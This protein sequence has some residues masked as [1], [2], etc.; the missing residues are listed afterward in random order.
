[1]IGEPK[2]PRTEV[3]LDA[4]ALLAMINGEPGSETVAAALGEAAI[5]A[6][7]LTEVVTKMID[8]GIP[9]DDAWNEAID[10]VPRVLAFGSELSR[11]AARLRISTRTL[12]LSLG[13]RACLALAQHLRLPALTTD[14]AWRSLSI[15]VEI[16]LIR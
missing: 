5:S 12:G 6:V 3:V 16:R 15:G 8:I 10:L 2:P 11:R 13:D 9:E 7:N 14:Q 4:S 1:V